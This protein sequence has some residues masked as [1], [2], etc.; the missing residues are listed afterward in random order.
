VIPHLSGPY[1]ALSLLA[2]AAALLWSR[3]DCSAGSV[4]FTQSSGEV[5]RYDLVEVTLA[6]ERPSAA[7]PFTDVAVEGT[8]AREGGQP[9]K[10]DGFCDSQDGSVFHIRFMPTQ[11]GAHRYSVTY[12]HGAFEAKH[13][14]AFTVRDGKRRGLVRVDP[15]HPWHFLWEGTGEHYFWNGTTTY[16]LLGPEQAWAPGRRAGFFEKSE[17]TSELFR[18]FVCFTRSNHS[19]SKE[20][21]R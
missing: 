13:E 9:V 17:K 6:V 11:A 18:G 3:D 2:V 1:A 14:G 19:P 20:V 4:R 7:N 10:L 21:F 5:E 15:K 12:R 8:F 16:W